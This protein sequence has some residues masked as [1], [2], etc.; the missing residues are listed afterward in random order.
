M[1][2][3]DIRTLLIPDLNRLAPVSSADALRA[4]LLASPDGSASKAEARAAL[5]L[6]GGSA[7]LRALYASAGFAA[8]GEA[9]QAVELSD[10]SGDLMA[11]F[12]ARIFALPLGEA[13]SRSAWRFA[14]LQELLAALVPGWQRNSAPERGFEMDPVSRALY[15]AFAGLEKGAPQQCEHA[16]ARRALGVKGRSLNLA[17]AITKHALSATGSE[18]VP[19]ARLV[20]PRAEPVIE[21]PTAPVPAVEPPPPIQLNGSIYED[22]ESLDAF[23]Q[24]IR[25]LAGRL[26]TK[27]YRGRVAIA[28]VYDEGIAKGLSLGSLD[29]FKT[30]LVEAARE[31]LIDLERYDIAGPLDTA[32]R[33]RSRTRL[34]R[35]ER[36]FIVN[37][38]I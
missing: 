17:A 6:L 4:F 27:P 24:A 25:K 37:Q 19:V 34:G 2:K 16:L 5:K 28:Q 38:W 36:H 35:D 32:L 23:A 12:L 1:D 8:S 18:A 14:V 10:P 11:A 22:A 7:S 20:E 21:I 3:G 13:P 26:E 30:R 33:E 15:C 9:M 31:S 29:D